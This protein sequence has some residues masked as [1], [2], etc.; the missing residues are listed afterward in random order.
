MHDAPTVVRTSVGLAVASALGV[1]RLAVVSDGVVVD[2]DVV[3]P[4]RPLLGVANA[5]IVEQLVDK[6]TDSSVRII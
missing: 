1:L 6:E 3:V 2:G 5:E 4:V